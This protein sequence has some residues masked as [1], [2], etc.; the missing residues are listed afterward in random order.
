MVLTFVLKSLEETET[1]G[2]KCLKLSLPAK[3]L[4][5]LRIFYCSA[6]A[7]YDFLGQHNDTIDTEHYSDYLGGELPPKVDYIP[8]WYR[9]DRKI[10]DPL[11]FKLYN[12]L[13][14]CKHQHYPI[15]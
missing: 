1:E 4:N 2:T 9:L 14:N 8:H 11:S 12:W 7:D 6:E 13:R 5:S 15:S 10:V 3:I